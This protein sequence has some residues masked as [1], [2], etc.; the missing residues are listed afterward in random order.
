M[1]FVRVGFRRFVVAPQ[2]SKVIE[3]KIEQELR[4]AKTQVYDSHP[5]LC[6]R[7]AA[8]GQWAGPLQVAG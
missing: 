8:A 7:I 2:I 6:D 1:A 5:P 4:E 3:Q